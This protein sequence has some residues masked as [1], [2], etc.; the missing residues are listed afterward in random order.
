VKRGLRK[1]EPLSAVLRNLLMK[2]LALNPLHA[3]ANLTNQTCAMRGGFGMGINV[4]KAS[5]PP[6]RS[7]GSTQ[8]VYCTPPLHETGP[9]SECV[10]TLPQ[11]RAYITPPPPYSPGNTHIGRPPSPTFRRA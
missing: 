9:V 5:P 11:A 6:S 7:G 3:C 4:H 10:Y 8:A 2:T 1:P